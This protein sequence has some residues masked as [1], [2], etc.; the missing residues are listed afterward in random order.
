MLQNIEN[1]RDAF[2]I[3]KIKDLVVFILEYAQSWSGGF[4]FDLSLIIRG[5]SRVLGMECIGQ[6]RVEGGWGRVWEERFERLW[7]GELYW[8]PSP[9]AQDDSKIKQDKSTG[10]VAVG[11]GRRG[12]G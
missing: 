12:W 10:W 5:V 9:S 3:F 4:C 11:C 1:K 8:D 2:N 7:L 6:S